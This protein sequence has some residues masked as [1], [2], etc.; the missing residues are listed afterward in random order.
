[1]VLRTQK[2]NNNN[3]QTQLKTIPMEKRSFPGGNNQQT[4]VAKAFHANTR[5]TFSGK[6]KQI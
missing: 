3:I 5:L 6:S 1:M 4:D 2:N